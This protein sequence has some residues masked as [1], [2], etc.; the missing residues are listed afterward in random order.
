MPTGK[1]C[2]LTF[3]ILPGCWPLGF[4]ATMAIGQCPG[5]AHGCAG[6]LGHGDR[7]LIKEDGPFEVELFL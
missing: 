2:S 7:I 6:S 4:S 3:L 5:K 1:S